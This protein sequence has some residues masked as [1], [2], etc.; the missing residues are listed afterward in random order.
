MA[1]GSQGSPHRNR[2]RA[3]P[4]QIAEWN[5]SMRPRPPPP[6]HVMM[7]NTS[8]EMLVDQK[9]MGVQT[10]WIPPQE[11]ILLTASLPPSR[12][13]MWRLQTRFHVGNYFETTQTCTGKQATICLNV[14]IC[15]MV[16]C[17]KNTPPSKSFHENPSDFFQMTSRGGT[18]NLYI[19]VDVTGTSFCTSCN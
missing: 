17:R 3:T 19:T 16:D 6:P 10:S 7:K 12:H 18:T 5:S 8:G 14:Q 9:H 4:S 11:V 1:R 15:Y 13:H 2:P